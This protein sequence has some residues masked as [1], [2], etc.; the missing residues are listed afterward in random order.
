MRFLE[1]PSPLK[2]VTIKRV[3][4]S[5]HYYLLDILVCYLLPW[6]KEP[7]IAKRGAE[8]FQTFHLQRR[9]VLVPFLSERVSV[10][11]SLF[12]TA[13]LSR[14]AEFALVVVQILL[15]KG[16][17]SLYLKKSSVLFIKRNLWLQSMCQP[18]LSSKVVTYPSI[19]LIRPIRN[20]CVSK[21]AGGRRIRL[22]V[23]GL[24]RWN[25]V[26][27]FFSHLVKK[28]FSQ[29]YPQ[30]RHAYLFFTSCSW[31]SWLLASVLKLSV[32]LWGH[33]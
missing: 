27:C 11:K 5:M 12:W 15:L 14:I 30:V 31:L 29:H 6:I 13:R 18:I 22:T 20:T 8:F 1:W 33:Q 17:L 25:H 23:M 26:T 7:T 28:T 21:A 10:R 19:D 16:Y 32:N 2:Y 9:H 4:P 24:E 3:C